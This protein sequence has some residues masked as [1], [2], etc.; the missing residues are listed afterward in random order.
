MTSADRQR[1]R[2][3]LVLHEGLRLKPYTDTVGKLTIGIGR[4]L[5]DVGIS[6]EE[7][8][9]LLEHDIDACLVDLQTFPGFAQLDPVRQR[10]LVDM[11]FNL[12]P[13]RFRGFKRTLAAV[14]AGDY[15][16]AAAGMRA[17][18][19]SQQVKTRAVRLARMMETGIDEVPQ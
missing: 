2:A 15:A 1:L 16:A 18:K 13:S 5:T 14:A 11:R 4:N 19:W 7:A 12:G 3:Q 8:Y 9:V 6:R 17:S 10:V